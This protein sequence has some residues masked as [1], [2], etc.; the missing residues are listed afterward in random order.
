MSELSSV[1]DPRDQAVVQLIMGLTTDG[2]HHK[3]Y[4]LEAAFR[5]LCT[6]EYV[7]KTKDKFQWAE[8]MPS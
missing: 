7:E 5:A 3:Q 4:Y 2:A 6:A 1:K 8:G